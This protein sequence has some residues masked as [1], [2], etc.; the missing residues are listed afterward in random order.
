MIHVLEH[1]DS[2]FRFLNLIIEG[3]LK[4]NGSIFIEVPNIDSF[5]YHFAKNNWAHF[6]P[7]FHTNH[8]SI[9]SIK[10]YCEKNSLNFKLNSTF[11][12]YNS[13][14]GMTSCL[15]SFFGYRGI[16]FEDLKSKKLSIIFSFLILLPISLISELILSFFNMGSI[17]KVTISR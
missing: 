4:K 11:S 10:S 6:T 2:P 17:L 5:S 15:L 9:K 3:S 13:A 7:H 8:F 16:I 1:I 12:F 14:M